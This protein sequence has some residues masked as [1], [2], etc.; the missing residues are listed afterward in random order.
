VIIRRKDGYFV[1]S[2]KGKKKLGGPYK[3]RE[4][5]ER[6]LQQVEYFKRIGR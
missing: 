5:A 4:D 1:I 2:E 6:R 3:K